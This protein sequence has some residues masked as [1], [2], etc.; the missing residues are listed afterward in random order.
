MTARATNPAFGSDSANCSKGSSREASAS[1]AKASATYLERSRQEDPWPEEKSDKQATRVELSN[2][3]FL[4]RPADLR[5]GAPFQMAVDVETISGDPRTRRAYFTLWGIR[6]KGGAEERAMAWPAE[7]EGFPR[8]E[9]A[10]PVE[11]AATRTL[12]CPAGWSRQEVVRLELEARHAEASAIATSGPVSLQGVVVVDAVTRLVLSVFTDGTMNDREQDAKNH[13]ESNVAKLYAMIFQGSDATTLHAAK[14][15]V[16]IGGGHRV[17]ATAA[18]PNRLGQ[19]VSNALQAGIEGFSGM[20]FA[21]RIDQAMG[22]VGSMVREHPD[23]AVDLQLFG[24][25]RGAAE[26]IHLVNVLN[27]RDE[28]GKHGFAD[29]KLKIR[30]VGLFDPVAS[31]GVPGN[32]WDPGARLELHADH[33]EVVVSLI[34]QAEVR[35]LF[36]LQSI[37]IPP[38]ESRGPYSVSMGDWFEF[39]KRCLFPS[40]KWEEWV[41]PGVHSDVGGGYGPEEWIPDVAFRYDGNNP[42]DMGGYSI[43]CELWMPPPDSGESM[44]AYVYRMKD[45]EMEFGAAPRGAASNGFWTRSAI[46]ER[47]A[48]IYERKMD[49]WRQQRSEEAAGNHAVSMDAFFREHPILPKVRSRDNSLARISLWVMIERARKAGVKWN[50]ED[51]LRPDLLDSVRRIPV[52]HPLS[53]LQKTA[54]DPEGIEIQLH[55]WET[56][57]WQRIVPYIHDSRLSADLPQRCREIYFC[58]R[59]TS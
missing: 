3:R 11:V 18:L 12:E 9:T 27:D 22:W 56:K 32:G 17:D 43:P 39:R 33:V 55:M 46:E 36:D 13:S 35:S 24:F 59:K 40:P 16:G 57:F 4:T 15:V 53:F 1:P 14:Y 10:Q 29:A 49:R 26:A 45:R 38:R 19:R 54:G 58:G 51:S 23:A 8:D 5:W 37:R 44:E 6:E 21:E 52:S 7:Q 30:F 28:R 25:S 48:S 41:M 20:G 50:E 47:V 34:A 42:S 31:I 2:C